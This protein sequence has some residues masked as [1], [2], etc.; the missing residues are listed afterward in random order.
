MQESKRQKQMAGLF[1]EELN[2]IF[3]RLGLTMLQ[4]GMVSISKVQVTP[5]LL[6]ARVHLSFF[7]VN[8]EARAAKTI[9]DKSFEV[10]KMLVAKIKHQVRRIPVIH[11]FKDDTLDYVYKIEELFKNLDTEE[12]NTDAAENS[13][14]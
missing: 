5:D 7:Q 1:A 14:N 4:G 10:K 6:E 3:R 9:A 2:E 11:Y 12:N 13:S 8:D